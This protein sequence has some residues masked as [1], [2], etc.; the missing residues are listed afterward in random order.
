M[1][2]KRVV[3]VTV[4]MMCL[5]FSQSLTAKAADANAVDTLTLCNQ[6]RKAVG[7]ADL[8]WNTDLANAAAIR[9]SEIQQVW[10][11]TRPDGTAYFTA[12][13]A[14]YGENLSKDCTTPEE[15][16]ANWMNSP[17]HRANILDPTYKSCGVSVY[18]VNG[19]WYCAEEFGY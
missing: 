18:E 2:M 16:V 3:I 15:C 12:D 7:L 11:H 5:G 1:K 13:D 14:I 4:L 19:S 8:Q 9:S 17:L 10:S 6:Q